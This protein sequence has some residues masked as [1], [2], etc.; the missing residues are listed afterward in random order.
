ML[1]VGGEEKISASDRDQ[2][3]GTA[4]F[5]ASLPAGTT[6]FTLFY[7]KSD[8][9]WSPRLGW[10][11]IDSYARPLHR[12]NSFLP[13]SPETG[14]IFVSVDD[15]PRLLRA[16][17][18]F[19]GDKEQRL[20]HTI[21]VGSPSGVHY[22]YNLA[23]GSP[24]CVWR[25]NFLNATPMWYKRGDGSFRPR[26]A[27]QYLF[28]SPSVAG[29]SDPQAAFPSELNHE[30]DWQGQGYRI[31]EATGLPVFLYQRQGKVLED[32]LTPD[33][34]GN[35]LTRTLTFA[36]GG[37]ADDVYLK[38]AEGST[39]TRMAGGLYSV[40]QQF[41]VRVPNEQSVNIR[42]LNQQQELVV[43]LSASSFTYSIIW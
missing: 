43:P 11:S 41:Y 21:G 14:P 38:L 17:L 32:A 7:R 40:D 33:S 35:S 18:D 31:D 24:V 26:G 25:G 30:G 37:S 15:E 27:V 19:Q 28:A 5:V 6:P 22:V 4:T 23:T 20:T 13:E 42:T 39:I 10:F 34:D 8:P 3:N 9:R 12:S 36:D 1:T 16:F 2:P 29:L